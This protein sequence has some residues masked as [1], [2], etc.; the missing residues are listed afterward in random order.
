MTEEHL[1]NVEE[2]AFDVINLALWV[3]G[4]VNGVKLKKAF[5]DQYLFIEQC[6]KAMSIAIY[7]ISDIIERLFEYNRC[8]IVDAILGQRE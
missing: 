1:S 5:I 4:I 8:D 2:V 7:R 6:S 3:I